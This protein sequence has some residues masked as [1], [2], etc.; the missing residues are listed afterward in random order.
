MRNILLIISAL[1]VLSCGMEQPEK[2][3]IIHG[4]IENFEDQYL[5]YPKDFVAKRNAAMDSVF[6]IDGQF[7]LS[8]KVNHP[9]FFSIMSSEKGKFYA[10]FVL[11]NSEIYFTAD[12]ALD[13]K[14]EKR[15]KIKGSVSDSL[16]HHFQKDFESAISKYGGL[17]KDKV[18]ELIQQIENRIH[19]YPNHWMS[20]YAASDLCYLLYSGGNHQKSMKHIIQHLKPKFK[21]EERFKMILKFCDASDRRQLG[22]KF[23]S[24]SANTSNDERFEMDDVLGNSYVFVDC[25]ASWCGPCRKEMPR[26]KKI[27]EQYKSKGFQVLS[28]SF[29]SNKKLWKE[30]IAYDRIE[31]FIN[32]SELN[33]YD[34]AIANA[35]R[36]NFI[37]DNF[38]LDKEGRIVANGLKPQELEEMLKKLYQ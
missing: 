30:A 16:Q 24:Y 6:V 37:P 26:I 23:I 9:G 28:V 35:Y 2:G 18:D 12:A 20:L 33:H 1:L 17:Q 38:L 7:T 10:S 27:Q 13:R 8:G 5:Y 22:E 34:N 4:T 25:W 36:I 14:D 3:F 11:E 32:V 19:Q 31:E 29:D 21:R 15:I